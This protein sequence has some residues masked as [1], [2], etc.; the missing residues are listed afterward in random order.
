V[1]F[2]VVLAVVLLL[3]GCAQASSSVEKQQKGEGLERV[4]K[5]VPQNEQSP[6]IP[7][8]DIT[9]EQEC[10]DTGIV[11]KCFSVSTDAT[12]EEDLKVITSDILLNNPEYLAI[13][14]SFYPNKPAADVSGM[15]FAFKN[16]QVA[17][18]VLAQFLAQGTSVEDEVGKAMANGGIYVVW[19]AD[20]VREFAEGTTR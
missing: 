16:E 2:V 10:T 1:R 4:E 6:Y 15:G 13:V 3:V 19:V 8:Y 7:A 9:K 12:S 18:V 20:E 17:R 14:V 5:E 11:G